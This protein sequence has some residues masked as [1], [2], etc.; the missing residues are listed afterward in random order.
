MVVYRAGE[1]SP[2]DSAKWALLCQVTRTR[3]TL[4]LPESLAPGTKVWIKARYYNPAGK[5]GPWSAPISTHIGFA[6][7]PIVKLAA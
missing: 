4:N 5:H 3:A 2:P 7:S 1:N 6:E